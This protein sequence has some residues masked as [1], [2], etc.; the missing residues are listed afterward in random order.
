[1]PEDDFNLKNYAPVLATAY[2]EGAN[3]PYEAKRHILSTIFNRAESGKAE[4]GAQNGKITEVLGH[5]G[6]YYSYSKQSPKFKEAMD[7]KFP[8]KL[9]EDS[10]KEFMA[11]L[12]GMLRGKVQRSDALFF[13]TP[14]EVERVKKTKAMNMDLLEEVDRPGAHIFYR[15]KTAKAVKAKPRAAASSGRK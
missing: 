4:F 1:M 6:A 2:A 8:D 12:S 5:P 15:Y 3:Q 11:I 14:K 9:S 10:Y 13:L 7:Q